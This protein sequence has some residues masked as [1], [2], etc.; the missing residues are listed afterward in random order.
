MKKNH[1]ILSILLVGIA[2]GT[3]WAIRG[4]FGHEPGAAFAGIIGVA[5]LL[6]VARREDW[7][8]KM[9]PIIA[10]GAIGWGTTGMIS[11]GMVVGY[12]RALDLL[13]STY[14]F[15]SLFVI[16]GLFGLIGGGLVGLSLN[17]TS[18]NR[19]KWPSLVA[20]MAGGGLIGY[21]FLI[22]QAELLMTPPRSEAWAICLG[23][24]AAMVWH[25]VRNGFS[26]ALRVAF[27]AMLGA[28]FGFSFGNLLQTTGNVL[29]LHFNMWNV[30]EYNIGFWGGSGMAYGVFTS[31]WPTETDA[32][33][34]YENNLSLMI[35]LLIVPLLVWKDAFMASDLMKSNFIQNDV[36]KALFLTLLTFAILV[37]MNLIVRLKLIGKTSYGSS[38]VMTLFLVL[39]STYIVWSYLVTGMF[40]GNFRSEQP[41]YVVNLIAFLILSGKSKSPFQVN[42]SLKFYPKDR[43]ALYFGLTLAI[44]LLLPIISQLM[45]GG[46]PNANMRFPIQ[47]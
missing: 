12:C 19:V 30:M 43:W 22:E 11:Y 41:L 17:S 6:L 26:P 46:I 31:A 1:L 32:P 7:H 8:N 20:E 36:S 4:Q 13:N 15:L 34:K 10:A 35:I 2:F 14:G 38:E 39:F 5:A 18:A 28:G 27:Y 23:A 24:G 42:Q 3:S 9:L 21:Y 29:Q 33:K 40:M 44:I 37:A 25:M 47:P 45:H 16:G